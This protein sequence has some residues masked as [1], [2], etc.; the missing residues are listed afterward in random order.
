MGQERRVAGERGRP[1]N[2]RALVLAAAADLF[3]RFGYE[4]VAMSEVAAAVNVTPPALY[5]HFSSKEQ[6]LVAVLKTKVE[7]FRRIVHDAHEG[8]LDVAVSQ[9]A[10]AALDSRELGRLWHQETRTITHSSRAAAFADM[11]SV[12]AGLA[13]LLATQRPD[14]NSGQTKVLA[15]CVLLVLYSISYHNVELPATAYRDL[16]ARMTRETLTVVPLTRARPQPRKV[17][18][19]APVSRREQLL[20]EAVTLFAE[21]GYAA[22]GVDDIAAAAGMAGPSVYHHFNSKQD[23]LVAAYNRGDEWLRHGMIRALDQAQDA[24]D[25]LGRLLRSHVDFNKDHGAFINVL[26]GDLRHL[27]DSDLLRAQHSQRSYVDEWQHLA[28]A[29]RP[30]LSA[31]E[32]RIRTYAAMAVA[33]ELPRTPGLPPHTDFAGTAVQVGAVLLLPPSTP[34]DGA[35]LP[36]RP[37]DAAHM[38]PP[39]PSK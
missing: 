33:N 16:L 21:R 4:H 13:H 7:P 15:W 31:G 37:Q 24:P 30:Q 9:L 17:Q 20:K 22:V 39:T 19:F 2:R 12:A 32:A 38:A 29:A 36:Q 1:R 26:L 5:R 10:D 3:H 23:I 8:N 6:L 11:R 28:L 25:A 35:T 18:G 14:L 27:P 34:P